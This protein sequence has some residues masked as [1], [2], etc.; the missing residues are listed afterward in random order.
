MPASVEVQ[1][2]VAAKHASAQ[3]GSAASRLGKPSPQFSGT[4]S[5]NRK[6][7]I[8][9]QECPDLKSHPIPTHDRASRP[10]PFPSPHVSPTCPVP[11]LRSRSRKHARRRRDHG[12]HDDMTRGHKG[13]AGRKQASK[14]TRPG[15][16]GGKDTAAPASALP[17]E[18]RGGEGPPEARSQWVWVGGREGGSKHY[19]QGG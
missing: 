4:R 6:S 19:R 7:S 16:A 8:P 17:A 12:R 3:W 18:T 11:F 9:E 1:S 14:R 5:P 15:T 10:A 2:E 13:A